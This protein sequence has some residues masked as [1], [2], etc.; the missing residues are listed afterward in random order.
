VH[1]PG[2]G[3]FMGIDHALVAGLIDGG[4]QTSHIIVYD[5]TENDPGIDALH[6]RNRNL[7]EAQQIA[8]L[9]TTHAHSDPHSKIFVTAHSGGC[10]VA[11]WALELLPAD[12][13]VDTVLLMAPALS[14]GY[15]L[16]KAL[17]HVRTHVYAFSSIHDVLILYTGTKLFGTIDGVLTQAAGFSGFV[18]PAGANATEYLKLVP[19]PYQNAWMKLNNWGDHVGPMSRAFAQHVLAPL[20]EQTPASTE[21]SVDVK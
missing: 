2:I 6:A 19:E 12:V 1:V 21:P 4:V 13:S 18:E 15:D 11:V 16:T 14:P 10:G 9:I 3:G 20:L 7:Q 5:W 8:D 17:S